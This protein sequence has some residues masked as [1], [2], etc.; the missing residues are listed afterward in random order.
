MRKILAILLTAIL[1]LNNLCGCSNGSSNEIDRDNGN[2]EN[3]QKNEQKN[4]VESEENTEDTSENAPPDNT[5]EKPQLEKLTEQVFRSA[6]FSEGLAAVVVGGRNGRGCVINKNGEIVFDLGFEIENSYSVSYCKFLNGYM[7]IDGGVCDKEG[8]FT[9]PED[10][11]AVKFYAVALE[12]GYIFAEIVEADFSSTKK[13]LGILN[14]KFEWVVQPSEQLY[15]SLLND[16]GYLAF[17]TAINTSYFYHDGYVYIDEIKKIVNVDTG[18]VQ[19]VE[20]TDFTYPS[21]TWQ[22][23]TDGTCRDNNENIMVDLSMYENLAVYMCGSFYNGYAPIMFYNESAETY[24]FTLVNEKGEFKFEPVDIKMSTAS[25]LMTDGNTIMVANAYYG[26]ELLIKT[27]DTNGNQ[28]AEFNTDSIG[29]YCS[30]T[31]SIG[32][33]VV[34]INGAYN[35]SHYVWYYTPEFD[36]LF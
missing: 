15:T 19:E 25:S 14:T 1:F 11:G 10:V 22:W 6:D 9:Y 32:N 17:D 21:K 18:I 7:F 33:G 24:F 13:S 3:E 23:Y 36:P 4:E 34:L 28:I 31:V 16:Y 5:P 2:V 8:N 27:Y 12:G 30:Y 26:T 35:Y 29:K 20:G